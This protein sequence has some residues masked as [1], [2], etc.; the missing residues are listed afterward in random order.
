MAVTPRSFT[1][2][3]LANFDVRKKEIT[4]QLV[5]AVEDV[6]FFIVVDHDLSIAEIKDVF[7]ISAR[8]FA[9]PDYVKLQHPFKN[10]IGYEK[11]GQVRPSTGM[12]DPKESLQLGFHAT[13]PNIDVFPDFRERLENFMQKCNG[14]SAQVSATTIGQS[15]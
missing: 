9:L 1:K 12:P 11:M 15:H 4:A 3:S 5:R 2:I 14:I 13:W 10:N 6:G 8:Y 7:A